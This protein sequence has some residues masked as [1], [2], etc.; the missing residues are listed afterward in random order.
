[1]S[2]YKGKALGTIGDFG[3]FSFHEVPESQSGLIDLIGNLQLGI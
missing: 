1:M 3:C 2:S